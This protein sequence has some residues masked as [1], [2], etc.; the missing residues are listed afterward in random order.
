[1][2]SSERTPKSQL[3]DER[4]LTGG[5]WNLPKKESPHPKT[6]SHSKTVGGAQSRSNP[7]PARWA[8]NWRKIIPKKFCHCGKVLSPTSGFPAWGSDRPRIPRVSDLEGQWDLIT[9]LPQDWR[10]QRLQSWRPQTKPCRTKTQ[11][12]GAVTP[13]ETAKTTC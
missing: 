6:R 3:A 11:R 8:T 12:K 7:M 9:R 13:Q 2:H 5:Y 4:P 1:M 10:K